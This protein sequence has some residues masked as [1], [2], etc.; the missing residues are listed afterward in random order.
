MLQTPLRVDE[1]ESAHVRDVTCVSFGR[2]RSDVV[3]TGSLDGTLRVWDLS[4]YVLCCSLL[5]GVCG[6]CPSS[7]ACTVPRCFEAAQG[8]CRFA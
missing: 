4:E 1:R 2:R 3:A 8:C 5:Y 6:I 7:L